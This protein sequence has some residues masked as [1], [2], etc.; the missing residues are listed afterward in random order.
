MFP[1]PAL[2]SFPLSIFHNSLIYTAQCFLKYKSELFK[3][4]FRIRS[5]PLQLSFIIYDLIY[6][7]YSN[8]QQKTIES[9]N[10]F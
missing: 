9:R 5:F 6:F 4:L 3:H 7:I 8:F 2:K 10:A 1:S